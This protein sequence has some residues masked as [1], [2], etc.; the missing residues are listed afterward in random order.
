MIAALA[1]LALLQ[2]GGSQVASVPLASQVFGNTRAIRIYVPPGYHDDE[3]R[4]YPVLY[5]NDGFAVFSP[6]GWNAPALV[7]SLVCAGAIRPII[8]IGIDNAA[9]P[10]RSATP[11]RDRAAEYLPYR[12]SV[13]E[14]E[15]ITPL[16][17]RYPAFLTLEVMAL[18]DSVFRTVRAPEGRVVG[19][20]SYGGIA[21]L[22]AVLR[23]P[24][25]FGGLLLES[26]PLHISSRRLMNDAGLASSLPEAIYLGSGT[27]E[28][29]DPRIITAAGGTLDAFA[30][31]I[32]ARFPGTRLR[33][34][35]VEGAQHT[36]A[37]WRARLPVAL[38]FFFGRAP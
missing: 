16:G 2:C 37:A 32:A 26:T 18:V 4:R 34:N 12:D 19:G 30:A 24:G 23:A 11:Q 15:L 13:F 9:S 25:V 7:D 36:S 33:L 8:L 6:R 5:L 27:A 35:E 28:S 1:A 17:D 20:S 29:S 14:P 10:P 38:Q 22:T 21:A 31:M 3:H